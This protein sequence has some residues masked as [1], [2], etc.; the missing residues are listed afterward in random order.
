MAPTKPPRIFRFGELELD[1]SLLELRRDGCAL[2][3]EPKPLRLLLYLIENRA[4]VISKQDLFEAIWPGVVVSDTALSSAL[5]DVRRVLGDDGAQ[6]RWIRTQR[7]RGY[8]WVGQVSVDTGDVARSASG[9]AAAARDT[10]IP[11]F[12]I[13]D[14]A[15]KMPFV[16]RAEELKAL[17]RAWEHT[18]QGTGGIALIGG[19]AGIGKTRLLAQLGTLVRSSGGRVLSGRCFAGEIAPPYGL[20]AQLLDEI[21]AAERASLA[22]RLGVHAGF[23]ARLSPDWAQLGQPVA[24]APLSPG[25]ERQRLFEAIGRLLQEMSHGR[26]LLVALDDLH[27]CDADTLT[28][29]RHVARAAARRSILIAATYRSGEVDP[30]S[31]LAP[32]IGAL[33]AETHCARM[34]LRGLERSE[35]VQ[36]LESMLTEPVSETFRERLVSLSEGN[37]FFIREILLQQR[38]SGVPER[39]PAAGELDASATDAW[40]PAGVRAVLARRLA[41]LSPDARRLLGVA[42]CAS[43]P[44]SFEVVQRVIELGPALA[45]EVLDEALDAQLIRPD[46]ALDWYDFAHA[47]IR[48]F[49]YAELSPSRQLRLHRRL[50]EAM[51]EV[52][53]DRVAELAPAI[54]QQYRSSAA[55]PGA[56]RGVPYCQLAAEQAERAAAHAQAAEHLAGALALLPATAPERPRL[57]AR[58]G[59]ALAWSLRT[60]RAVATAA[61]AAELL[62]RSEGRAAAAQYLADAADAVWSAAYSPRASELALLGLRW[63]GAA[64]DR[65][66]ARLVAHRAAAEQAESAV[67]I[68]IHREFAEQRE[69]SRILLEEPENFSSELW[70]HL[71][72]DSRADVLERAARIP[73]PVFQVFRAGVYLESLPQY[74]AH[75]E[76]AQESGRTLLAAQL[77]AEISCIES[78]LGELRA[79]ESSC[80]RAR[81]LAG[82]SQRVESVA[83]FLAIAQ[84]QL[85][86]VRG[87]GLEHI[88]QGLTRL[89]GMGSREIEW[90]LGPLRAGAAAVRSLLGQRDTALALLAGTRAAVENGPGWAPH[91]TT[92][93]HYTCEAF[94][95]LGMAP[96]FELEVHLRGKTLAPD[97]RC[98]HADA[99]LSLARLC[100]LAGRFDEA[101]ARFSEA[102]R[103]LDEQGAR[104]LRA[105]VD[106][107]EARALLRRDASGDRARAH[108]LLERAAAQFA[109]I[110]MS[111]WSRWA[112]DLRQRRVAP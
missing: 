77:L 23:L 104:P 48:Q 99:R 37:P 86:V 81:L 43:G 109:A 66:W 11:L 1:E 63:I 15:S 94:W 93:I 55:L 35:I 27:W 74:R 31:A 38:E 26:P 9:P 6:Q 102:R 4:R 89:L 29:L 100:A 14:W 47:L 7:G 50:A 24:P 32:L 96:D 87:E 92:M 59:L 28:L 52:Y 90:R 33:D 108:E 42:A 40:L 65:V 82:E 105:M 20:F 17:A 61:E 73:I 79:A 25:E 78:A 110:G 101:E 69:M 67:P 46:G 5:K 19:E 95:N 68:G 49:L 97:F 57:L 84:G 51:E 72:F 75:A 91:Y 56:S 8:R 106:H 71:I 76:R 80:D 30:G 83:L 112:E 111:G 39:D 16:G 64:R 58:L 22:R 53:A 41:N 2:P 18:R 34:T 10:A 45:L 107:D 12:D 3:I 98:P 44:F 60:A 13:W 88:A 103:V 62:K 70:R 21:D 54:A 85:A 36:L